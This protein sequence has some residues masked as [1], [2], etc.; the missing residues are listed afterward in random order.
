MI[1]IAAM[2]AWE[3]FRPATLRLIPGALIGV[4]AGDAGRFLPAASMSRA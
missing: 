3:R 4:M 1:T 2:L